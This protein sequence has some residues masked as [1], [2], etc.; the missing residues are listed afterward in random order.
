MSIGLCSNV[1]GQLAV[2]LMVRPPAL[3]EHSHD[4]YASERDATLGSLKR[5]ATKLTVA[6]NSLT[7]VTCN[8]AEG[9]MYAFPEIYLP[10]AFAKEAAAL[11]KAPDALASSSHAP[12]PRVGCNSLTK[13]KVWRVACGGAE[14]LLE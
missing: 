6:L 3:G 2:G 9:A 4:L 11:G 13:K 5:R 12:C 10:A 1:P 7:G 8:P 14:N